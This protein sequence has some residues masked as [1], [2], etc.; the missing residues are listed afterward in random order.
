MTKDDFERATKPTNHQGWSSLIRTFLIPKFEKAI[1]GYVWRNSYVMDGYHRVTG[2]PVDEDRKPKQGAKG[3]R[4][5]VNTNDTDTV[6]KAIDALDRSYMT[7]IEFVR[8]W[9][10]KS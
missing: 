6:E 7:L 9:D 2:W 1:P 4:V 8:N 10:G 3:L 5:T